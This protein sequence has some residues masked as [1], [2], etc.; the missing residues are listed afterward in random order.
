MSINWTEGEPLPNANQAQID[1]RKFTNYSLQP[2]NPQNQGKWIGFA[3]IGYPVETA[4]GRQ[5]ATQ[6]IVQQIRRNLY[7]TPAYKSNW[8][9]YL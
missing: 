4:E 8:R 5:I 7:Y 9:F 1:L 2:D 6:D 3:M